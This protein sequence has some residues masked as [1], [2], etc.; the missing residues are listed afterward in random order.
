MNVIAALLKIENGAVRTPFDSNYWDIRILVAIGSGAF[1]GVS[2]IIPRN[3][4]VIAKSCSCN[5]I[6]KV[7]VESDSKLQTFGDAVEKISNGN[8]MCLRGYWRRVPWWCVT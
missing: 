8:S 1:K 6:E 4:V 5:S 7:S 3:V 2:I